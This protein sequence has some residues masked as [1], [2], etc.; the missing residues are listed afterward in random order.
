MRKR[1]GIFKRAL[2]VV[3]CLAVLSGF[4]TLFFTASAED[5]YVPN[6]FDESNDSKWWDGNSFNGLTGPDGGFYIN[7]NDGVWQ[8]YH[9]WSSDGSGNGRLDCN[10][11]GVNFDLN[12]YPML[13]YSLSSSKAIDI[14]IQVY[15]LDGGEVDWNSRSFITLASL[16]AGKN[17]GSVNLKDNS[18][19][20]NIISSDGMVYLI[21]ISFTTKGYAYGDTIDVYS[22]DFT[23]APLELDMF[24]KWYSSGNDS[25]WWDGNSF[26]GLTNADGGFLI[27]HN[28]GVWQYYHRWSSDGAGNGRLDCNGP[29]TDLDINVLNTLTYNIKPTKPID[30]Y[31]QVYQIDESGEYV[32]RSFVYLFSLDAGENAGSYDL[33]KCSELI[34]LLNEDGKFRLDGISY[35]TKGFVFGDTIDVSVMKL[36]YN[37]DPV[38]LPEPPES[39]ILNSSD[40]NWWNWDWNAGGDPA[41]ARFTVTRG[42]TGALTVHFNGDFRDLKYI[43]ST[44]TINITDT[45]YLYVDFDTE[46]PCNLYILAGDSGN[47]GV[48]VESGISAGTFKKSYKIAD[49]AALS[50]YISEGSVSVFGFRI[51]PTDNTTDK[52]IVF[53]AV[54]FGMEGADFSSPRAEAPAVTPDTTED[55][56][57]VTVTITAPDNAKKVFYRLADGEWTEYTEPFTVSD[58]T[59]IDSRYITAAN[60][61]SLTCSIQITNIV[62]GPVGNYIPPES[63]ILNASDSNW[64][65]WDWNAATG[66]DPV[67]FTAAYEDSGAITVHFIGDFRDLKYLGNTSSIKLSETPYLYIDFDTDF[68]CNLYLL[69]DGVGNDGI[70]IESDIPAGTFKKAYKIADTQALKNYISNGAISVFGFRIEPT[71]DTSGRNIVF[72]AVDFGKEGDDFSSPRAA[73]P[74]ISLNT[75]EPASQVTVTLKAPDDAKKVFYRIGADGEWLEY[76]APLTIKKNVIIYGRYITSSYAWSMVDSIQI[77]N[78]QSGVVGDV[79]PV[80]PIWFT[81]GLE[82]DCWY[83][84]DWQH[85]VND[86]D[87][88][89]ITFPDGIWTARIGQEWC[90]RLE[91]Q[92]NFE[93]YHVT[94]D[95]DEQTDLF[96]KISTDFTLSISLKVKNSSG[97]YSTV[98]LGSVS[99]GRSSGSLNMS[100]NPEL[101]S[102]SDDENKITVMGLIFDGFTPKVGQGFSVERIIFDSEDAY[103]EGYPE[104][105]T[106][107]NEISPNWFDASQIEY[108]T[109][110]GTIEFNVDN[111]WTYTVTDTGNPSAAYS[112]TGVKTN[113]K[114]ASVLYFKIRSDFDAVLQLGFRISGTVKYL[115]VASIEKG[116]NFVSADL[117]TVEGIETVSNNGALNIVGVRF[118]PEN[119][120]AGDTLKVDLFKFNGKNA[121]YNGYPDEDAIAAYKEQ[122]AKV[123]AMIDAIGEVTLDSEDAITAAREAYDALAAEAKFY[124]TN[125]SVLVAAENAWHEL[126]MESGFVFPDEIDEQYLIDYM[127]ANPGQMIDLHLN[128]PV[129]L[130]AE[131]IAAA[132]NTDSDIQVGV[133]SRSDDKLIYAIMIQSDN[134]TDTTKPFDTAVYTDVSE[135]GYSKAAVDKIIGS[136]N[137]VPFGLNPENRLPSIVFAGLL[138]EDSLIKS[139]DS[140]LYLSY[141]DG[142]SNSLMINGRKVEDSLI[143]NAAAGGV[144]IISDDEFDLSSDIGTVNIPATGESG[145]NAEYTVMTCAL[146]ALVLMALAIPMRKKVK[147]TEI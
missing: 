110:G 19:I 112:G 85:G 80:E 114:T 92:H 84:W 82:D 71:E 121:S 106:Q 3:L 46:V 13:N 108:W 75:T 122:A 14:G 42:N 34:S 117:N 93:K 140:V 23:P 103:Y 87:R 137:A 147:G 53:R 129:V 74:E 64:W 128:K 131:L 38:E 81:E 40:S 79:E 52:N 63:F 26:S 41:S 111:D 1:T 12:T 83:N 118:V 127:T 28:D 143:F 89:F 97:G 56:N 47:N 135:I 62:S 134:M 78:I 18:E 65:N 11:D 27:N 104:E 22:M 4:G 69:V 9:R 91:T 126:Y 133:Y 119:A 102:L 116:K 100:R 141:Y 60:T 67:R 139:D 138:S 24:D 45:P 125:Y 25:S 16:E 7:H 120:A 31:A 144:Y 2:A 113:L 15:K 48:L 70:K 86:E 29:G 115:D 30:V 49:T 55:A 58:N 66:P 72:R 109:S 8:Y 61:W 33:R 57:S 59:G 90:T 73:A 96:Y 98:K 44:E 6:W 88:F 145:N 94:I 107:V 36:S 10:A 99:D 54:D 68:A 132:K 77:G 124:V 123:E 20:M 39:F 43:G 76:T 21:G 51:E 146:A 95:L 142:K 5:R 17:E 105:E 32:N 35:Q 136:K 50:Q 37:S 130:S 101:L